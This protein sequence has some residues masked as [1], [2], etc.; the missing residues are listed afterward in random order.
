M[1][2]KKKLNNGF[3]CNMDVNLQ[4]HVYSYVRRDTREY[5]L[6]TYS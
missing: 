6:Y 4:R 3:H 5:K 1:R 2:A